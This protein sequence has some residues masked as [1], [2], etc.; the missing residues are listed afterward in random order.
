MRNILLILTLFC[1]FSIQAQS[2]IETFF[3]I[4]DT[5][6]TFYVDGNTNMVYITVADS[7]LTG[8]D[9]IHLFVITGTRPYYSPVSVRDVNS[10][11][12]TTYVASAGVAGMIPGAG[13]TRTYAFEPK[14]IPGNRFII[15]RSN[16][17]TDDL[18]APK[19]RIVISFKRMK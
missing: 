14:Q 12:L 18:Y 19:T 8:T 9:S 10:T 16:E 4:G 2:D 7:T 6:E 17:S 11:A 13:L 5:T 1:A 15:L 3:T